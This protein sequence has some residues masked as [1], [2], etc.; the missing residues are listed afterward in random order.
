MLADSTGC[1]VLLISHTIKS[2]SPRA[3]P[4]AAVGGSSSGLVGVSR[5]VYLFG[6][7]PEDEEVRVLA[8][9]KSVDVMPPSLAFE[10]ES[11]EFIFTSNAEDGVEPTE[12]VGN[13]GRLTLVG[14]TDVSAEDLITRKRDTSPAQPR[15]ADAAAWLT[16][17]LRLG[18]RPAA[19][20]REDAER[21]GHTWRTI[22][23]AS[24]DLGI[25]KG[26]GPGSTW[27]LPPELR[28]E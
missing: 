11:V 9:A 20:I 26:R 13:V 27:E 2:I 22:R 12:S 8:P 15:R 3:H 19:E 17:Y 16:S 28:G 5:A 6:A 1:S 24:K 18:P 14:E 21:N 23:R 10:F 25:L 7:D 4:L